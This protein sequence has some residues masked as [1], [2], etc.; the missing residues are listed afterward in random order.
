MFMT[1]IISYAYITWKNINKI[2]SLV[3][4]CGILQFFIFVYF[5][6]LVTNKY[7]A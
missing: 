3:R 6:F 5:H 1:E 7:S 2:E 4:T